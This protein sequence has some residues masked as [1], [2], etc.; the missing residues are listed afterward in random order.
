MTPQIIERVP[1]LL[2][3]FVA[4]ASFYDHAEELNASLFAGYF[5]YWR[6]KN[7]DIFSSILLITEQRLLQETREG[8]VV[9]VDH[10]LLLRLSNLFSNLFL[11]LHYLS[12]NLHLYR[13]R[14]SQVLA[15]LLF[16]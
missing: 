11:R 4:V 15:K 9:G 16:F 13:G 1:F 8:L 2:C 7:P 5:F 12:D 10:L 14:G 3:L 6:K